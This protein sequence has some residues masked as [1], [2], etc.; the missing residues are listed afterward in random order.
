MARLQLRA[1][2]RTRSAL[3]LGS[4]LVGLDDFLRGSSHAEQLLTERVSRMDDMNLL[5]RVHR[6]GGLEESRRKSQ[7][8]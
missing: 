1:G 3:D 7:N 8:P 2:R 4:A 6:G 5:R